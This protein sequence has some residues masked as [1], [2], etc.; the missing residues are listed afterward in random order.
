MKG[1]LMEGLKSVERE[2]ERGTIGFVEVK[3][4]MRT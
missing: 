2:K 3:K 4:A 1:T